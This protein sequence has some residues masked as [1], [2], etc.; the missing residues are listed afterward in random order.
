MNLVFLTK[1]DIQEKTNGLFLFSRENDAEVFT[2]NGKT[3]EINKDKE[4]LDLL[5][6]ALNTNFKAFDFSFGKF[7]FEMVLGFWFT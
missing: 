5:N 2:I 3:V 6:S 1:E 4:F 7:N